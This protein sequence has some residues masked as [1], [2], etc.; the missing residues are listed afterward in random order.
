MEGADVVK[1]LLSSEAQVRVESATGLKIYKIGLP[2][3]GFI[4]VRQEDNLFIFISE[5]KN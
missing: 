2:G 3:N 4:K 5:T 1:R